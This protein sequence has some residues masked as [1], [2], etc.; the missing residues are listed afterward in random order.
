MT[1]VKRRLPL[2]YNLVR[3]Q[4]G[5]RRGNSLSAVFGNDVNPDLEHLLGVLRRTRQADKPIP[6]I[7]PDGDFVALPPLFTERVRP[8]G[9]IKLR[10]IPGR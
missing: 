7:C 4:G 6:V 3:K 8:L 2:S 10:K 1:A 9:K 5:Q